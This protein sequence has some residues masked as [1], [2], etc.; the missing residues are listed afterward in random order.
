MKRRTP[1]IQPR[2]NPSVRALALHDKGLAL[3][4]S[5]GKKMLQARS[6]ADVLNT[7]V[8]GAMELTH[9]DSGVIFLLDADGKQVIDK[10][11]PRRG[12]VHP[13]PRLNNKRGITR[14]IISTRQILSLS[15]ISHNDRVNPSLKP[16]YKCMFGIPLL[17]DKFVLGVLYLNGKTPRD[18][19]KTER[20]LLRSFVDHAVLAI[21]IKNSE[22]MYHAIPQCVFLKDI[23]SRFRAANSS[24]CRSLTRNRHALVERHLIGKTDY[25]FYD[26]ATADEYVAK[27]KEVIRTRSKKEWIEA[28][29]GPNKTPI[30][31]QVVKTPVLSAANQVVGVQAI[32]WDVTHQEHLR[33]RWESLVKQSP[34]S[35][36]VHEHEKITFANPQALHMFG[37]PG[38]EDLE[39]HSIYEFLAPRFHR[40]ASSLLKYTKRLDYRSSSSRL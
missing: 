31:V 4:L 11:H 33:Q 16:R 1:T 24:F 18:L 9:T 17:Q 23:H 39:G 10:F 35:V 25:D 27:D 30:S 40:M 5:I 13:D 6:L 34:D 21:Q 26:K 22:S 3:I 36:V 28:H 12:F 2:Q 37:V 32:Y 20:T 14:Q 38:L 15:D 8:T 7:I 29:P 19:T